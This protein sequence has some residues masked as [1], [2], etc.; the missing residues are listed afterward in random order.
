MTGQEDCP[1]E[2]KRLRHYIAKAAAPHSI[3]HALNG[4]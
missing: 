2:H 1:C 3:A 4:H